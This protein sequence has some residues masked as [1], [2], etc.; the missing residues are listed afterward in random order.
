MTSSRFELDEECLRFELLQQRIAKTAD[1]LL[2]PSPISFHN[3]CCMLRSLASAGAQLARPRNILRVLTGTVFERPSAT[4]IGN[5]TQQSRTIFRT[6]HLS[7]IAN[8][9]SSSPAHSAT[10]GTS[11]AQSISKDRST[12]STPVDFHAPPDRPE[13]HAYRLPDDEQSKDWIADIDLDT[14][15]LL[16]KSQ[17]APLRFL[18]LYGSLRETSYSR[19][20]A[21]EMARLLE[22][23]ASA[24]EGPDDCD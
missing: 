19:L 18:V 20:L 14:A 3:R 7:G 8:G 11:T 12:G 21:F 1:E 17:P 23:S 13:Y 16:M 24:F 15:T 4:R 10:N 2:E 9:A 22:V 5:L 6:M